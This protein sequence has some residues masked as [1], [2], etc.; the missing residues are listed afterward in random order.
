M[1]HDHR[2][3]TTI[4]I[5]RQGSNQIT[6]L[7]GISPHGISLKARG[8]AGGCFGRKELDTEREKQHIVLLNSLVVYGR[9]NV[10]EDVQ[11]ALDTIPKGLDFILPKDVRALRRGLNTDR[12]IDLSLEFVD[13]GSILRLG[14]SKIMA[15]DVSHFEAASSQE[16]YSLARIPDAVKSQMDTARVYR[17]TADERDVLYRN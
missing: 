2:F 8:G 16:S 1:I 17:D 4:S 12:D 5:R 6:Y 14:D 9:T 10:T 13:G 15:I 7:V 3:W 11:H